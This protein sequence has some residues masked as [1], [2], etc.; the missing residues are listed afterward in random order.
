MN[1]IPLEFIA[2]K[3][4][5]A[6]AH[7][8][9]AERARIAAWLRAFSSHNIVQTLADAIERGDHTKPESEP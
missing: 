2:A 8:T 6:Y 4:A 5:E 1:D 9:A 3:M 7:G